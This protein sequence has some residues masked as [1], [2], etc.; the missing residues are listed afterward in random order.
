VV[1]EAQDAVET[2]QLPE[3]RRD[4]LGGVAGQLVHLIGRTFERA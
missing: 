4:L 2:A 3:R 1:G